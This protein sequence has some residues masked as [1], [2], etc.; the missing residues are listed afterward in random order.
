[1]LVVPRKG[2]TVHTNIIPW[3]FNLPRYIGQSQHVVDNKFFWHNVDL[4]FQ[5]HVKL[6]I[7]KTDIFIHLEGQNILLQ[8]IDGLFH[9]RDYKSIEWNTDFIVI[10]LYAQT[11]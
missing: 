4:C 3:C 11:S 9:K 8:N 6:N 10:I 5:Y 7:I 2:D 1:M